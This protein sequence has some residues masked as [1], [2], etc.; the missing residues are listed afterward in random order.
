MNRFDCIYELRKI[1]DMLFP[2]DF[3]VAD[4]DLNCNYP[5]ETTGI[6]GYGIDDVKRIIENCIR[7]FGGML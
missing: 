6:D 1:Y 3:D 4:C 2:I 7:E 5:Y